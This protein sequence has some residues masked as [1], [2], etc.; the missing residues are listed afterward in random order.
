MNLLSHIFRRRELYGDLAEEMR[1]HLEERTEQL[2]GEGLSRKEAEQSARRAFG[3][4]TLLEERSREVWQMPWLESLGTDLKLVFRRLGK[5]PGFAATVLLTLAIGIGANTAVF[6]VLN[7]V[8]FKPLPYPDAEQL[9]AVRLIAPGA[10]GL[11]DFSSGLRLSPSMYFTFAEQNRTFQS[12]G[13]WIAGIANV[14]GLAQPH[15]V[16]TASITD[17][18]LQALR[19]PPLFGR[20]LL[21]AEQNP[22]GAKAVMLSYGYWQRRFGGDPS[23]IGRSI[24]VDSQPRQIVGVMPQ[25]FRL[26]NADFDLLVPLGFDRNK[27][28]LAG[29]GFQGIARLKPGVP[30]TQANADV[31]RMLPIWMD[32]WS[33]GPGIDS[34]FYEKWRIAA[35]LRPLKEEVIGSIGN[36]LWLVMGTI[37][38][39]MLIACTNVA[40]LLLVRADARRQELSVRAALGAGRA[41]IAWELL[42]ESLCLG[43]LGGL[44]GVGI[45]YEGLRILAAI[46][47][48]NLPRL[49]EISLDV[50]SLGFTL[51]LSVLSGLLF[52]SIPSLRYDLARTAAVLHG[53]GRTASLSRERQ[54]GRDLL[55]VAQVA[56]ALVLL[57]SAMLMIRTFRA[58]RHV[59]PGFSR[60]EHLQT[61]RTS[62]PASLV[63]DPQQVTRIQNSIAD[64]LAAIPGVTSVGFASSAPMEGIEANWD[65]IHFEGKSMDEVTTLRLFKYVAPGYFQTA[66]TRLIAGRELTWTEVYGLRPVAI[67]SENLARESFGTPSAALGKRLR[68]FP[69]M[70][71]HEV[72]G[73][74]EDVRENGVQDKAPAMVYWP[75][76]MAGIYGPHTFDAARTVTFVLRSDRAGTEGLLSEMREAVWSVNGSL[77]LAS[78]RT[79]QEIYSQSLARTSFTLVMLGIAGTMAFVLGIIGIYGVISYAVLQRTREIGIRLALGEQTG[80]LRWMFIRSALL[81]TGSGVAIGLAAAAGLMRLMKSLL[82]GVSPLDPFTYVSVLIVLTASAV[83]ASYLPARR[84]AAVNPVEALR[85]E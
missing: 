60:P 43:L 19:A 65:D 31:A 61:M 70:A 30:I 49:G 13:V 81:L 72:V 32:S 26:V 35:A 45:A 75:S 8:L 18:V 36:V 41:R 6:S 85:A 83:L 68:E 2:M 69:D 50:R 53:V 1:L 66:G 64:N 54:R 20:W 52:G 47:P 5:S 16:H 9:V 58:L 71:W 46:G 33:N 21:P 62:I 56:M 51:F 11:A 80:R 79:M 10:A 55:V 17:G 76:M 67:I 82:F 22:H 15:E 84:A 73:V 38:V 25:G 34:H 7:S 12:L 23:V 29:F 39:V 74:V 37:G 4:S 44:L 28:I 48:A 3:N 14:T 78:V 24:E 63:T 57:V 42:L 27:Q 40:N 59:E 77:P